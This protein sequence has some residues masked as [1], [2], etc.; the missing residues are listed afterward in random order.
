MK[1]LF[2][3]FFFSA[4]FVAESFSQ[5][6]AD[7]VFDDTV[8]SEVFIIIDQDSLDEILD[9]SNQ[10]SKYEYPATFIFKK[11]IETDT[12]RNIGFRLRGNTSRS[13]QKKSFKVSFN[14][15]E[16]GRKYYGLEKMNLNGEHNDP[17][18]IRSKI[19]W[20]IF[21]EIG[22]PAPR[23]NHV[24]LYINDEFYGLY[25][26]VE[27]IDEEFVQDRFGSNAGNLY[28]CLWPADLSFR[29]TNPKSYKFVSNGRRAYDL[30]TN[31]EEDDYSDIAFLITFF[32]TASDTRFENEI[33]DYLNVDG[34]LRWMAVDILTGNWDNYWYNQN[35]FYLYNN[36]IENRFEF[37]PYDYDNT[38]GID[39]LGQNWATRDINNWAPSGQNRPLTRRILEVEE[40]KNR[41]N[42]YLNKFTS[43][44]FTEDALFAEIDRIKLLVQNAASA[45]TYRTRD[46][47]FSL[48]DYHNSFDQALS[49]NPQ[50]WFIKHGLKPFI[51]TRINSTKNQLELEDITPIFRSVW[52]E[53]Q[54]TQ[55]GLA[56]SV[57]ASVVDESVPSVSLVISDTLSVE[58]GLEDGEYAIDYQFPEEITEFSFYLE[59]TDSEE[60]TG[61]YPN[62]TERQISHKPLN[63]LNTILINEFM[64]DNETGIQDTSGKYE[65]WIEL[66]NPTENDISLSGYYL[67]DDLADILKWPLPDTVI[68]S[69]D[70]LLIW[71]DNDEEEG[72]LHTNF[73]LSNDGEE[74]GIFFKDILETKMVDT[75]SFGVQS[76]DI[77]Y[78][79][80]SDGS[81]TFKFF[82]E[83]TPGFA[84]GTVT[85]AEPEQDIP[86]QLTLY[87]NYP[88]PF[89]PTT[90]ISF[91]LSESSI[92]SIDVFA[93][94]G[95][96]VQNLTTSR[97]Q[98]GK[99]SVR[100]DASSLSSGVYFYRLTTPD[101]LLTRK[102]L[103]I[104]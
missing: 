91:S 34:L 32:E 57:R 65:D 100:F 99:H 21:G 97:Y 45:D 70:Y 61:R 93:V 83:P 62:N 52:H 36:P 53:V 1:T 2:L 22:L 81:D 10:L 42:F 9:P 15:F 88:N 79:R 96:L 7:W 33:E 26:N 41:L 55:Q 103:L 104:K 60:K 14:T 98:T 101:K 78:G 31:R 87:Q 85:S 13:S 77:S 5:S 8:L 24:R 6:N 102:M 92:V 80:T 73:G 71:A 27:H 50:H 74:L 64:A 54:Q 59:A 84:N 48:S 90:T 17:S 40:Y 18:I 95:R 94:D 76:D 58:L 66:Y 72:R 39:F 56:L 67:T 23:A 63:T 44:V 4:L 30:K 69:K 35:N 43:E 19:S 49:G 89:N 51:T 20:D 28:K 12:V 68:K 16:S 29:T 75:L 46:Y 86:S 25:I 37:I 3:F 11:G 82:D 38:L 47:G